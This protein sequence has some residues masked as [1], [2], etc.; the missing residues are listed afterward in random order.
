[1]SS[2]PE[3]APWALATCFLIA[4]SSNGVGP[5]HI[6]PSD[7]GSSPST[8]GGGTIPEI[9]AATRAALTALALTAVPPPPPDVSN[10]WADSAQAALF[11]Q[12]LFYDASFSG[13]LL[14]GDNDG[15]VHA[16]GNKGETGKV[17]CSGCHLPD[18]G[19]LDT[20]SVDQQI[21]LGAGWV[22]RRTPSLLDVS[23]SKLIT[24]IGRR[25]ALYNQPFGPIE[26]PVEMNSS[27]LFVAEQIFAHHRT[28]YEALFGPM[29]PL[30]DISRFPPLTSTQT[31]CQY[32]DGNEVC[33]GI[34]RGAPGDHAEYDGLAAADQDAVTRVI[35]NMGKSLGAYE[36]LLDCGLSR[37]DR[38][39]SGD[40]SALDASEQRGAVLFVTKGACAQCHSGP[41]FSDEQFHDV[42]I[43]PAIVATVFADTDDDGASTGLAELISDPLNTHGVYSDGDDGRTPTTVPDSALGSFRTPKLRCATKR[44]SFMHT[45][46]LRSLDAVVS[47]F[48]QGGDAAG[49]PGTNELSPLNLTLQERADLVAF[50]GALDG[51]GPPAALLGP[52]AAA[53]P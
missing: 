11:G 1:M 19:F 35:V 10:R 4:C 36:R 13:Q 9:S 24:W 8:D 26:N 39:M 37:F 23:R 27:R 31:G 33:T 40:P 20:R 41:F 12:R 17:A 34:V 15:T 50:L 38:F 29:P 43:R 2:G 53:A 30:S 49:Y 51:D 5:S 22:F 18:S 3:T 32:L 16:L 7:G 47:F 42:G 45:G 28:E 48:D 44:P 21:S 46:Q 52:P 25:D 6:K 14:D